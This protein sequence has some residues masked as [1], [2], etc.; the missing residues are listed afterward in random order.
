MSGQSESI[1]PDQVTAD[2]RELEE[3]RT[4]FPA[5]LV[6]WREK[7]GLRPIDLSRVSGIAPPRISRYEAGKEMPGQLTLWRLCKALG[8]DLRM[9]WSPIDLPKA[10]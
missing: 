10:G 1:S 2:E 4:E 9:F 5:R 3:R 8:I 6:Y 7:A